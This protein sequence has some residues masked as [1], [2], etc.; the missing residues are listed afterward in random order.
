MGRVNTGALC[1]KLNSSNA[2]VS[3]PYNN[4]IVCIVYTD[5]LKDRN[6]CGHHNR[7]M[8]AH[9]VLKWAMFLLHHV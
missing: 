5:D 8:K 2:F 6:M 3:A 4:A 7:L 1:R 9:D